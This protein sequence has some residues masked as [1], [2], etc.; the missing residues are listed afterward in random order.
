MAVVRTF[1][2]GFHPNFGTSK[3]SEHSKIPLRLAIINGLPF[4]PT[5]DP[6][7]RMRVAIHL[8]HLRCFQ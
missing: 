5:Y 6:C 7:V 1:Y 8:L 4:N 3:Q 2:V